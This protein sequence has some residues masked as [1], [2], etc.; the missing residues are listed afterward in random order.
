[1][2]N[3]LENFAPEFL[4]A[5]YK[6]QR[7]PQYQGNPLIE[8]LPPSLED[9]QWLETLF[10]VPAF[11]EEQRQWSANERIQLIAQLSDFMVPLSRHFEL[12]QK[13]DALIRQGYVGRIPRSAQ[14]HRVFVKLHEMSQNRTTFKKSSSTAQLSSSLI[15][16]S[17]MGK[18]TTVKRALSYMPEVIYHP[19]YGIYQIPYLH[20]ETPYDGASVK[21][22]A[23]SIFRKVDQLLPAANYT[24]RYLDSRIGA[25]TLMNHAA[26]ILHA[27]CVG[28]LVVDE[29]QNLENSRKNRDALMSLLVSASNEL[30][31]PIFFIG[32]NKASNLLSLNFRQAR[33]SIGQSWGALKKGTH[34][35]PD[36]WEYFVSALWRFQWI[37]TPADKSPFLTDMLYHHSQGIVDIAIK[38]FAATQVRAILEGGSETITAEL[39]ARVA[40]TE[41]AM[42]EPMIEA[43]RLNDIHALMRFDDIAPINLSEVIQNIE[44][45]FAGRKVPGANITPEDALFVPTCASALETLGFKADDAENMAEIAARDGAKNALEGVKKALTKSTSGTKTKSVKGKNAPRPPEEY[46]PGDYRNGLLKSDQESAL[47]RMKSLGMLPDLEK[48]LPV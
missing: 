31:V 27:H 3:N 8:A 14:S 17:G 16:L 43:L 5:E 15:G 6:E 34:N 22:I 36:E 41:L 9:T 33:R 30:G 35:A 20:I 13:L 45:R 26:R 12:A 44:L 11:R 42:V 23:H 28:L 46:P 1:M 48:I 25:E 4:E 19:R 18:T 24:E 39:I 7:I 47:E 10:S 37:R 38:L 2:E 40:K 32:T 21:G 29:I